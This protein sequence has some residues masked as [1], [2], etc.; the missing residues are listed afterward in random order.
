M[1]GRQEYT[2]ALL[3]VQLGI[4]FLVAVAFLVIAELIVPAGSIPRPD[5]WIP[6]LKRSA[7]RTK[8]YADLARAIR[9]PSLTE[10]FL[11]GQP[12]FTV[13]QDPCGVTQIAQGPSPDRRPESR[14]A[15]TT[16]GGRRRRTR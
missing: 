1:W 7:Q 13:A 5:Q 11:G 8:R 14:A 4:I 12:A 3:P 15:A 9:Q 10:L 2:P 6:G 16:A